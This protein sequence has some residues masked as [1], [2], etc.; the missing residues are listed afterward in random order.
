MWKSGEVFACAGRREKAQERNVKCFDTA[1]EIE[2]NIVCELKSFAYYCISDAAVECLPHS[3]SW[4]SIANHKKEAFSVVDVRLF[5]AV[6]DLTRRE[7]ICI[8]L[9]LSISQQFTGD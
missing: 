4:G 7:A 8:E 9:L 6:L 3:I 2:L 1:A 5:V